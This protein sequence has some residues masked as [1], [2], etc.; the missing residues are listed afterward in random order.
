[1]G[2]EVKVIHS[3]AVY[4]GFLYLIAK[5][6]REKIASW[7]GA[8]VFTEKDKEDK[9]YI[10]DGVKVYRFPIFKIIPHAKYT[11][12]VIKKQVEKIIQIIKNDDFIPDIITG[13]FSNP[14][15]EIIYNLK[16]TYASRTCLVMHDTGDSIKNIYKQNYPK[17]FENIDIWGFRSK[18]IQIGF[19]RIFG[20]QKQFFLCYSGIPEVYILQINKRDFCSDLNKFVYAGDLIKR[21]NPIALIYAIKDVYPNKNYH[22]TY[23]G[24]GAEEANIRIT[25]DSF[26]INDNISFIGHIPRNDLLQIFDDSDCFIMISKG[27]AFGL[28]YLEAMGRGCIT[29][30][31]RNEGI[32][33]VIQHSINGF[34]CEAGNPNELSDIIRQINSLTPAERKQISQ[35]AITTAKELNDFSAARVYINALSD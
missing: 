27:E 17:Y 16:Q 12:K 6:F 29:I 5:L 24:K 3:Q 2:Y 9:F 34:L 30:G 33:G 10:M 1:M 31:S 13:H 23:V 21:K 18:S 22:I 25:I 26:K 11:K 14:Q 28:V 35:N 19:E 32:D 20:K 4:P 7:T 15:L 8:V